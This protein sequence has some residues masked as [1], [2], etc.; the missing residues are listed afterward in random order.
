MP[1]LSWP[2]IV[3]VWQLEIGQPQRAQ[4][5]CVPG[6]LSRASGVSSGS[7]DS[8]LS[9]GSLRAQFDRAIECAPI[10]QHEHCAVIGRKCKGEARRI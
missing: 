1:L 4:V 10:E 8:Q 7:S 9:D 5:S 2:V 3:A 6:R